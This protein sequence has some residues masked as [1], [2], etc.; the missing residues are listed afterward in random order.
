MVYE[1]TEMEKYLFYDYDGIPLWA[2]IPWNYPQ[3]VLVSSLSPKAE[4]V[5]VRKR[6]PS[7]KLSSKRGVCHRV[8]P[9][10]RKYAWRGSNPQPSVP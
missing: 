1:D 2:D 5:R 7:G 8:S 6:L 10:K 9:M 4:K 3:Q